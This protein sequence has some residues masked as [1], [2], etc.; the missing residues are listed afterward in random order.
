MAAIGDRLQSW[1]F[2]AGFF[3]ARGAWARER[4]PGAVDL[5]SQEHSLRLSALHAEFEAFFE[6]KLEKFCLDAGA[7]AEEVHAQLEQAISRRGA[8]AGGPRVAC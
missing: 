2:E 1:L 8:G 7:T 5:G 6:S 4:A 3:D